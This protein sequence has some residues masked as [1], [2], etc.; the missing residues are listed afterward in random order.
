M[1]LDLSKN[2]PTFSGK[3]FYGTEYIFRVTSPMELIGIDLLT[4]FNEAFDDTCMEVNEHDH[5]DD[6][7]T[8][9]TFD[10]TCHGFRNRLI[11]DFADKVKEDGVIQLGDLKVTLLS[12]EFINW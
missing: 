12:K 8:Y 2:I 3:G 6:T 1:A 9:K 7:R 5:D 11:H 4:M 10:V